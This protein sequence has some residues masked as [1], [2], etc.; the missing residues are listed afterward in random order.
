[1]V[2]IARMIRHAALSA[3]LGRLPAGL[4]AGGGW[5]D[6]AVELPAPMRDELT[7]AEFG[8]GTVLVADVLGTYPVA[9][10]VPVD[11]GNA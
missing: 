9:L 7:G 2:F 5:R 11:G 4:A 10:L 6:T 1:M 3:A 8:A